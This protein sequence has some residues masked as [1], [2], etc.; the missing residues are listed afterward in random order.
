MVRAVLR[1]ALF[2]GVFLA[3]WTLARPASAAA[4][5]C[6]DRGATT[7]ASPP[8]LQAA[9]DSIQRSPLADSCSRDDLPRGS[10]IGSAHR[11]PGPPAPSGDPALP[12]ASVRLAPLA[13]QLLGT[14]EPSARPCDGVRY[15][16]ERPPRA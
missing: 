6:D 7:I 11:L 1:A 3:L 9:D 15:R 8:P 10:S 2:T 13:G 5:L 12:S 14:V 4:P 16:V